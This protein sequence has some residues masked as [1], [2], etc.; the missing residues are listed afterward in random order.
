M[1]LMPVIPH[2]LTKIRSEN[3]TR[4]VRFAF[5]FSVCAL[6]SNI[7]SKLIFKKNFI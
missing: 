4:L 1:P 6:F 5:M 7:I 3:R 2:Q